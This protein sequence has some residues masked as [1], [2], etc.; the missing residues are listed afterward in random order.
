M[1]RFIKME[2]RHAMKSKIVVKFI[3]VATVLFSM[4]LL[5]NFAAV[6]STHSDFQ[7]QV[8]FAKEN[9]EDIN[10]ELKKEYKVT[11]QSS[12][13]THIENPL[14][15]YK[16]LLDKSIFA[17]SNEYRLTQIFESSIVLFPIVFGVL[18]IFNAT[19]DYRFKTIKLK[20]VNVNRKTLAT[21]K[22]LTS[23]L[24]SIVILV[25]SISL[26]WLVG[27]AINSYLQQLHTF[28]TTV[29]LPLRDMGLKVAWTVFLAIFYCE[30][31]YTI[32]YITKNSSI[33]IIA[34][35]IVSYIMPMLN[36]NLGYFD[37]NKAILAIS[38]QV[39][40]YYGVI[41]NEFI[42]HPFSFY[43]IATLVFYALLMVI[44][45]KTIASNRSNFE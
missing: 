12:N 15:F 20:A 45:N 3:I 27:W 26:A 32:G 30:L 6:N 22:R 18:G 13:S 11:E 5:M 19:Y 34:I 31:G 38:A 37:I 29:S 21:G 39:F 43:S 7:T 41:Q 44:V 17:S 36:F 40:D 4:I 33:S 25:V 16:E 24:I 10:V 2:L 28:N 9:G 42:I 23:W 14:S 1:I 35:F 8:K